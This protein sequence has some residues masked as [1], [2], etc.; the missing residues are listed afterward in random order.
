[1]AQGFGHD[2]KL[3]VDGDVNTAAGQALCFNERFLDLAALPALTRPSQRQN[4]RWEQV[5]TRNLPGN[6]KYASNINAR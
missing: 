3:D 2:L 6:N 4:E 5:R 1:M